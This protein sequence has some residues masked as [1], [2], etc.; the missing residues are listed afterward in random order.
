MDGLVESAL[1]VVDLFHIFHPGLLAML[2]PAAQ[3]KMFCYPH[4]V[5][6]PRPA[7]VRPTDVLARACFIGGINW[8]N[9]P[10]L[11]WWTEIARAGLPWI[12]IRRPAASSEPRSNMPI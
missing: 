11:A 9:M 2:S 6:D 7:P 12:S 3:A 5:I 1:D 4:P 8:S 10:R